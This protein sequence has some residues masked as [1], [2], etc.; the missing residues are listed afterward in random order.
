M[1]KPMEKSKAPAQAIRWI[2]LALAVTIFAGPLPAHAGDE[3]SFR[4]GA[5]CKRKTD[6]F[7]GVIKM[8]ACHRVYCGRADVKD[9]MEI[10][11]EIGTRLHCSWKLVSDHC[12]C[13]KD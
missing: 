1:R 11:P 3:Q 4:P 10:D 6:D 13:V 7:P 8:D 9:I 2:M 12:K 5:T